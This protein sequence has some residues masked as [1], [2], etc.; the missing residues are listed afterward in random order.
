M[1][2]NSARLV[3]KIGLVLDFTSFSV[4]RLKQALDADVYFVLQSLRRTFLRDC[5]NRSDC[6]QSASG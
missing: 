3:A 2:T 4:K 6:L 1:L 5:R